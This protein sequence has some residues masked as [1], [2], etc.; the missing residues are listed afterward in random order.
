MNLTAIL[1]LVLSLPLVALAQEQKNGIKAISIAQMFE[2]SVRREGRVV[3]AGQISQ[4]DIQ[5]R[6]VDD[7]LISVNIRMDE[8]GRTISF[9][10]SK[11]DKQLDFMANLKEN[12]LVAVEGQPFMTSSESCML[13]NPEVYTDGFV[14]AKW[15]LSD[16]PVKVLPDILPIKQYFDEGIRLGAK[17]VKISGSLSK[18]FLADDGFIR[19]TLDDG[20]GR[21]VSVNSQSDK[22]NKDNW[23]LLQSIEVGQTVVVRGQFVMENPMYFFEFDKV[24]AA[25]AE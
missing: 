6:D 12:Q 1:A 4:I 17:V 16:V 24:F 2:E 10:S 21:T 20:T 23:K 13:K 5:R 7:A 22:G 11:G 9:F 25:T 14:V 3:V 8:K 15:K 18:K 19:L